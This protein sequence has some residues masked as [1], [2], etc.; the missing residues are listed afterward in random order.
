M[1][2][3]RFRLRILRISSCECCTLTTKVIAQPIKTR[4]NGIINQSDV[5][6]KLCNWFRVK[7]NNGR[8][9]RENNG[10]QAR[11]NNRRQARKNNRRQAREKNRRQAQENNLRQAREKQTKFCILLVEKKT[12]LFLLVASKE[13]DLGNIASQK[14]DDS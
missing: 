13:Y 14:G 2:P 12:S 9:A 1:F 10:P 11:E 5:I 6:E 7:E 3:R 4:L 8:Q